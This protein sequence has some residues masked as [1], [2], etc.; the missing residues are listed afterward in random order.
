MN[1]TAYR[2]MRGICL[3]TTVVSLHTSAEIE[4][5]NHRAGGILPRVAESSANPKWRVGSD[6]AEL[7]LRS[8]VQTAGLAQ[9]ALAPLS[10]A[11]A[12]GLMLASKSRRARIGFGVLALLAGGCIGM[13]LYRSYFT[14]L[15]W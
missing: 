2:L 15:G 6:E 8:W 12:V 4:W 5:W 14:S 10:L 11:S 7:V 9:Y 1:P 3:V 13:K